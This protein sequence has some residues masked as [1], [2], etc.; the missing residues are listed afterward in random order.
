M[1]PKKLH[2]KVSRTKEFSTFKTKERCVERTSKRKCMTGIFS[3]TI[4][5]LIALIGKSSLNNIL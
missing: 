4:V 3:F 5:L 1:S 2:H